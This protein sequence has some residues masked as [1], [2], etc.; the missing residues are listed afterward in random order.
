MS[1]LTPAALDPATFA[2]HHPRDP[3]SQQ[4]I[5]D[6]VVTA[7]VQAVA[8]A[9]D[10]AGRLVEARRALRA[11]PTRTP[12]G[13]ATELRRVA[14]ATAE[15]HARAFDAVRARAATTVD[16]LR[17]E[18]MPAPPPSPLAGE[19]RARLA[20][21]A[22]DERGR[23]IE[24]ALVDGDAAVI[25]SVL[26]APS[27]LSGVDRPAAEMLAS[28][29]AERHHPD[30]AARARRLTHALDDLDRAARSFIG[31]VGEMAETPEARHGDL[32]AAAAA[33]AI[34]AAE[35]AATAEADA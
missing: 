20:Q 14:L 15:R 8:A 13:A 1:D 23:A 16:G 11:D 12:A 22:R 19:V 28:R 5:L 4:V 2:R 3:R 35:V 33:G 31:F 10:A 25:G 9:Q 6:P 29:W 18:A 24:A 7:A 30:T 17:R 26:A 34:R 32:A 21:L 27:F